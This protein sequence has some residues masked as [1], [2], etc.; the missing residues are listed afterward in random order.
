MCECLCGWMGSREREGLVLR[1][2][3]RGF[4]SRDG[5]QAELLGEERFVPGR[6][7]GVNEG[8]L[9]GE[10]GRNTPAQCPDI[11]ISLR[12]ARASVRELSVLKFEITQ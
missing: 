9:W 12:E 5:Q 1:S 6:K 10:V 7:D 3:S 2:F 4:C 11:C 8:R